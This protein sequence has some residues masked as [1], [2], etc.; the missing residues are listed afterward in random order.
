M[1]DEI[2]LLEYDSSPAQ[3]GGRWGVSTE[4]VRFG[5]A[6]TSGLGLGLQV[7]SSTLVPDQMN[8]TLS[9]EVGP[10]P[11]HSAVILTV[12]VGRPTEV[13]TEWVFD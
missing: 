10:A 7:R 8:R 4:V 2:F 13:R 1:Y 11:C 12:T 6:C 9:P 5:S 3:A